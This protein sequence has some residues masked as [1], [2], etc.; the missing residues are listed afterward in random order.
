MKNSIKESPEF[1]EA[2]KIEGLKTHLLVK[3]AENFFR[4]Y[5]KR[6][7]TAAMQHVSVN[8]RDGCEIDGIDE[9]LDLI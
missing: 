4:Y 6:I 8:L 9:L 2:M 5:T 7:S 3:K 1:V